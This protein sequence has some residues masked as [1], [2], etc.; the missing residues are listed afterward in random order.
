[1]SSSYLYLLSQQAWFEHILCGIELTLLQQFCT[2]S[3]S[4]TVFRVIS[5]S[6]IMHV[7][8]G[9]GSGLARLEADTFTHA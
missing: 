4:T 9:I 7:F 8:T 1:M 2:A 6:R 3:A 5:D